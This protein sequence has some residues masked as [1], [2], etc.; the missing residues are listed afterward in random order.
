[1]DTDLL[2]L[3]TL[4]LLYTPCGTDFSWRGEG[5]LSGTRPLMLRDRQEEGFRGSGAG[6]LRVPHFLS[7]LANP[8]HPFGLLLEISPHGSVEMGWRVATTRHPP[9]NGSKP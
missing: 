8:E 4:F 5:P 2:F 1:M 3:H 6:R 9:E 7:P